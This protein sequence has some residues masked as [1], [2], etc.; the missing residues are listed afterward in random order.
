MSE[1]KKRGLLRR[2]GKIALTI[3]ASAAFLAL[4]AHLIWK[5]SGDD[6]PRLVIDRDGIKVY[7]IKTSGSALFKIKAERVVESSLDR[8]AA[9]HLDGSLENCSD[10]LP[11]CYVSEPVKPWDPNE[12][13]YVQL[14]KET[15]PTPFRPREYILLTQFKQDGKGAPITVEFKA[16][17]DALPKDESGCCFRVTHMHS[18]WTLTP[19]DAGQIKVELLQDIDLGM[20]YLMFNKFA[21]EGVFASLKDLPVLYAKDRYKDVSLDRIYQGQPIVDN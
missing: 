19:V 9:A 7:T 15:F 14:W 5:Y 11:S 10:W 6:K 17:P 20:P 12:R 8:A 13:N 2:L 3:V 4:V 18:V 16:M 21:P 1:K